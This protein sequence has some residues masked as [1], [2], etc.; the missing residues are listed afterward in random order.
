MQEIRLWLELMQKYPAQTRLIILLA[1]LIYGKPLFNWLR[2]LAHK[3]LPMWF[4]A[5]QKQ[6]QQTYDA[7]ERA[8]MAS[9]LQTFLDLER[10]E[11]KNERDMY[12]KRIDLL[13]QRTALLEHERTEIIRNQ[14]VQVERSTRQ[15]EQVIQTLI[16]VSQS[17]QTL[18]RAVDDLRHTMQTEE[19]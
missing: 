9:V 2:D 3:F 5:R 17:Q 12:E 13:E 4:K 11:R 14:A 18:T 16:T 7:R 6:A 8:G 19:E 10:K 15:S 1:L